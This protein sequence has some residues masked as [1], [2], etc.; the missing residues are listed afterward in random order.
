M[1][2]DG[3]VR[4][5]ERSAPVIASILKVARDIIENS[6][7]QSLKIADVR[8][9]TGVTIGSIY[10]YFGS[11]EGLIAAVYAQTYSEFAL[12]NIAELDEL[13]DT[14][15]SSE[16]FLLG[17]E[18]VVRSTT[19]RESNAI[20]RK[21]IAVLAAAQHR[22]ELMTLI[23]QQQDAISDGLTA[24]IKEAQIRGWARKDIDPR[25][26]AVFVQAF[27]LGRVVDDFGSDPI[28]DNAWIAVVAT[29]LFTFST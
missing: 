25:S 26:L 21:R 28:S 13:L 2:L 8:E 1:K 20:K 14:A 22:S 24:W 4:R 12:T 10:H 27:T 18:R 3:V 16:E 11:R 9:R 19:S 15:K 29:A 17:I 6:G 23:E 5:Q 7:E